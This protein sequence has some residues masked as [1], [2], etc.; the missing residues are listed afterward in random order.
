MIEDDRYGTVLGA[1][2]AALLPVRKSTVSLK[3]VQFIKG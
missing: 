2:F 3:Y 1:T